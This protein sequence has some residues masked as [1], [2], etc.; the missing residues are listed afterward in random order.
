[1][2]FNN[3]HDGKEGSEASATLEVFDQNERI[4]NEVP[5]SMDMLLMD[6]FL[7]ISYLAG[8]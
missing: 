6:G 1:M 5:S 4:R 8:V 3:R 2:A 7:E